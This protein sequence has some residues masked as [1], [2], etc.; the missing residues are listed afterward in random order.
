MLRVAPLVAEQPSS[1]CRPEASVTSSTFDEPVPDRSRITSL[2]V[3]D[4]SVS[5]ADCVLPSAGVLL[6]T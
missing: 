5:S 6:T 1:K 4:A 3:I 2:K